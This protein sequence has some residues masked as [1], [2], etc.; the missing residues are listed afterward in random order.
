MKHLSFIGCPNLTQRGLL[1]RLAQGAARPALETL[2]IS[3]CAPPREFG[4]HVELFK[5]V[6]KNL[7]ALSRV[8]FDDA[9][10][11]VR[12][13]WAITMGSITTAVAAGGG[14]HCLERLSYY[15]SNSYHLP[16]MLS[17][18]RYQ[19]ALVRTLVLDAQ[20]QNGLLFP[21]PP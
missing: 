8:E 1:M 17:M 19:G 10:V 6:R 20:A 5:G 18:F 4:N 9:C 12:D 3:K 15:G 11:D 21:S 16:H 2:K 13:L 14:R 7:P